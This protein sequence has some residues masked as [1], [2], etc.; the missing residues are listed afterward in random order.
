VR[1]EV[2]QRIKPAVRSGYVA[3]K[4]ALI[5]PPESMPRSAARSDPAA[6]MTARTSSIGTSSV[7]SSRRGSEIPVPRLSNWITL[8]NSA[9]AR[10][11]SARA[12]I[13]QPTS[14]LETKPGAKTTSI[15]P[16]PKT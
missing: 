5:I 11:N 4:T 2:P 9:S 12:G 3:A 16:S 14:M 10:R 6:S 13:D 8:A 15:G 7:S 1:A